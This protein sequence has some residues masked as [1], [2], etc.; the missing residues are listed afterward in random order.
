M[1]GLE[2]AM[3]RDTYYRIRK[4][5]DRIAAT[6]KYILRTVPSLWKYV[7][8]A[9]YSALFVL[10]F[11]VLWLEEGAVVDCYPFLLG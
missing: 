2:M 1:S 7:R 11:S 4:I 5:K 9:E 10:I 8:N 3:C 6:S